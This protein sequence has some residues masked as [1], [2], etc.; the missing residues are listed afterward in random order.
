MTAI[1][2]GTELTSPTTMGASSRAGS[3][4]GQAGTMIDLRESLILTSTR[5]AMRPIRLLQ[6]TALAM[7]GI[8]AGCAGVPDTEPRLVSEWIRTLYG[9]V[10]AE[11]L[12]PP[13]P[14]RPPARA[15]PD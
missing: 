15:W 9:R 14:S 10:R 7:A 3:S 1:P 6:T 2:R 11:R 13:V 5:A 8:V 12:S 4:S